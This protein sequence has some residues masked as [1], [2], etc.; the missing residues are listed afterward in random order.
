MNELKTRWVFH[1]QETTAF[2]YSELIKLLLISHSMNYPRKNPICL[3]Q[4]CTSL[5]NQINFENLKSSLPLKRFIVHLLTTFKSE[6]TKNQTKAPLLYLVNSYFYNYKPSPCILCQ[7]RILWK[8]RKNKDI[9]IMKPD[10]KNWVVILDQKL[11]D[12]AI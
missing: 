11:D 3:K 12:N 9:I 7:H 2:L 10:K 1:W 5:S 8:L 6:E 4:V